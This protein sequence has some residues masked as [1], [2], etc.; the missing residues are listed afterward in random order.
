MDKV[1]FW[2]FDEEF[3]EVTVG[4]FVHKY[5]EE[6]KQTVFGI[7]PKKEKKRDFF[8]LFYGHGV[9]ELL[10]N[11]ENFHHGIITN[12][13]LNHQIRVLNAKNIGHLFNEKLMSSPF[14]VAKDLKGLP[15][16]FL[17][18]YHKTPLDWDKEKNLFNLVS[19]LSK[20]SKHIY[21]MLAMEFGVNKKDCYVVGTSYKDFLAGKNAGMNTIH[22]R[23]WEDKRIMLLVKDF[24]KPDYVINKSNI[25][26]GL[27]K[28]FNSL[29]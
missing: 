24:G 28:L 18:R 9:D 1:F 17:M 15:E 23:G 19:G 26:N 10:A 13:D 22:I 14:F 21:E 11:Y 3:S 7:L 27:E 29:K 25:R 5:D 20:P 2:D 6:S 12:G 8:D 4:K 16:A